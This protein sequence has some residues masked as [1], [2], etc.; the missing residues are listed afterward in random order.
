MEN[1]WT[2]N[3]KILRLWIL[4]LKSWDDICP[5]HKKEHVAH[6]QGSQTFSFFASDDWPFPPRDLFIS[7]VFS[8][9]LITACVQTIGAL[10]PPYLG[11]IQGVNLEWVI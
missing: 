4:D 3:Q 2:A 8:M 10:Q 5:Y 1:F 6:T 11:N 7:C 9:K